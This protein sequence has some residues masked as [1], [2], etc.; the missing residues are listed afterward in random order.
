MP[1]MK[2]LLFIA[3]GLAGC[4]YLTDLDAP[5]PSQHLLAPLGVMVF[6]IA[7]VSWLVLKLH[8]R[9][10]NPSTSRDS[11]GSVFFDSDGGGGGGDC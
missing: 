3:L 11:G 6:G 8:N 7:L 10:L 4:W 5:S 1:N 2:A 9:G